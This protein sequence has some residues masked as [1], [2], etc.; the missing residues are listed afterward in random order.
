[1]RPAHMPTGLDYDDRLFSLLGSTR[2]DEG[3][4]VARSSLLTE[5]ANG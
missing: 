4:A 2:N 5:A 1:M 3:L